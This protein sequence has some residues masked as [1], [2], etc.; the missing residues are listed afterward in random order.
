M[1]HQDW[2]VKVLKKSKPKPK[3]TNFVKPRGDVTDEDQKPF[4]KISQDFKIALQK[5]RQEKK[6]SQKELAQKINVTQAIVQGYENGKEIPK[7]DVIHKLN[8]VLGV[9]LPK[10]K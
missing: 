10:C 2:N 7:G 9:K 3:Q 8:S 6:W 4:K 1:D 5:A